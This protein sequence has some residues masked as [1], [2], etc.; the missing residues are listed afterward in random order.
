MVAQKMGVGQYFDKTPDEYLTE[1]L[2]IGDPAG[3]D[4]TVTGSPGSS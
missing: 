4:S 3:A 1:I 2:H